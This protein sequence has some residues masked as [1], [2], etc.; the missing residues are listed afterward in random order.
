MAFIKEL[1]AVLF[2][3]RSLT[4]NAI[5]LLEMAG[6]NDV[7]ISKNKYFCF[8]IFSDLMKNFINFFLSIVV[9][10]FW[11]LST[12]LEYIICSIQAN[13]LQFNVIKK[14]QK[15]CALPTIFI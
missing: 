13:W 6:K 15:L 7:H 8:Y 10:D 11:K 12:F 1:F 9:A 5:N 3:A 14:I 2:Y 4:V